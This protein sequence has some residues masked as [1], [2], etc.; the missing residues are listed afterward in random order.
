M[1]PGGV[2]VKGSIHYRKDR[3]YYFVKWHMPKNGA[4]KGK[5]HHIYNYKGEK[6][7][8]E[9]MAKKLLACMQA[10]VEAGVF[11]IEKYTGEKWT[12]VVPYMKEW[13]ATQEDRVPDR[14]SPATYNDYRNS[15]NRHLV[16]FF[17]KHPFQLHEIQYDVLCKLLGAIDRQGK[18]KM[19]VMY[20][21]R[22]CLDH[23]WRS[24]RIQ[25]MPPF[26]RKR[27]YGIEEKP[28]DW[29]SE[30]RQNAII[31][32]IPAEH[33]PIFWWLK[34]H[35]RRPGEAMALHK[36]DF[37]SYRGVFTIRRSF[38]AKELVN[39]TKTHKI[40]EIPCH[41]EFL[42]VLEAM[43]KTF[44]P[45]FFVNPKGRLKG[46]HYQHE[47]LARLWREACKSVNEN[48]RMY[49]GLKHSSCSQFVNERGG[50]VDELQMLT[51][52]A[53]RESVKRYASVE[54]EAK[55][56]LMSKKKVTRVPSGYHIKEQ[57]S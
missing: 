4:E 54:V 45:F 48:I 32:A 28:I 30:E 43:P 53:R 16:P 36:A 17:E 56:A 26:P 8:D 39:Y 37:D 5:T 44:G 21:L 42:P 20:C 23:A 27:E 9:R 33:Q 57:N 13:L 55:R 12:D 41:P 52:H 38:S 29:V 51:D 31:N 7:Y 34:Y 15:V 19:N 24:Q 2:C 47:Y 10:D 40:H 22:A 46:G 14:L 3:D 25:A 1:A 35:F 50:T 18:G 11:R 49:A 6:C